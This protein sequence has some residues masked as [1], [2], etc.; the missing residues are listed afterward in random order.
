MAEAAP[1]KHRIT[2]SEESVRRLVAC[3]G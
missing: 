1:V 2:A 3:W